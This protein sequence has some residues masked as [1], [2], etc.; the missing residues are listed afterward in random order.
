MA[1]SSS[2]EVASG[3]R[4]TGHGGHE[5][6]CPFTGTFN[7]VAKH[8]ETCK[9]AHEEDE[10]KMEEK[11]ACLRACLFRDQSCREPRGGGRG[12]GRGKHEAHN[13]QNE[14]QKG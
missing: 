4:G 8:E 7:E 12:R 13:Q 3:G 2:A 5:K 14:G 1:D 9:F 11:K 10:V 6:G